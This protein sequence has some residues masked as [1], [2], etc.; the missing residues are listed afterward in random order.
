MMLAAGVGLSFAKGLSVGQSMATS[1]EGPGMLVVAGVALQGLIDGAVV[2][3]PVVGQP[4][5]MRRLLL[6][7]AIVA[8]PASAASSSAHRGGTGTG[9]LV[10]SLAAGT[11]V[12]CSASCFAAGSKTS[13]P[14]GRCGACSGLLLAGGGLWWNSATKLTSDYGLRRG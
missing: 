5:S 11:L 4:M 12:T 10:L 3:A 8:D 9:L 1:L 2:A 6:L 13:A 7:A 14:S